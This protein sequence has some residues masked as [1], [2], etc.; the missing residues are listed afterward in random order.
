MAAITLGM[1]LLFMLLVIDSGRLYMEKRMLQRVVDTAALEASNLNAV[2][3]G[4]GVNALTQATASAARNGFT[5]INGSTLTATCGT[6]TT[7]SDNLRV[8]SAST[9]ATQAIQIV[10]TEPV[11]TSVA[12]GVWTMVSGGSFNTTTTLRAQ[13]TAGYVGDPLAQLTIRSGLASVSSSQSA[14]LNAVI[15]GVLGGSLNLTAVQYQGLVNTNV[16]LLSFLNQAAIS[17]GVTAGDYNTL[18]N[19]NVSVATLVQAAATVVQQGGSAVAVTSTLGQI[20][21][22]GS[23][24]TIKLGDLIQAATGTSTAGLDASVQLLQLVQGIVQVAGKGK[25]V[26]ISTGVNLGA[27]AN[28]S[29]K[30][31]LIQ[32]PQ[33]SAIG[34]PNLAALNPAGANRIYVSTAQARILISFQSGLVNGAVSLATS[35][36][37][38]LADTLCLIG[39]CTLPDLASNLSIDVGVSAATGDAFV[40]KADCTGTNKALTVKSEQSAATIMLGTVDSASFFSSTTPPSSTPP[41]T[42]VDIGTKTCSR[43]GLLGPLVCGA[44]TASTIGSVTLG[45][46]FQV[47][48]GNSTSIYSPTPNLGL[49]PLYKA[50]SSTNIVTN[51][52]SSLSSQNLVSLN[53]NSVGLLSLVSTI[54]N[55][56]LASVT[57][58]LTSIL[59]PLLDPVINGLLGLLGVDVANIDVGANLSCQT[60]RAQ[61]VL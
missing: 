27:L 9:T 11:A 39:T 60:G 5:L 3:S 18:L 53:T 45:G 55:T 1:A 34:N 13:A 6:L 59:G 32:P 8:F 37:N 35:S 22:L 56:L 24:S 4:T 47:G 54:V 58:A 10:A 15:V 12:A 40:V 21:A 44:R 49:T 16:N 61:L 17:V 50:F 43:A 25:A 14:L 52:G 28:L 7:G 26:D 29:V 48:A 19:T 51:L 38:F 2:C 33:F 23:G 20:S 57:S 46:K 30:V 31:G 36:V 41:L 42:L